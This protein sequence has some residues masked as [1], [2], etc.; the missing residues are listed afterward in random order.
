MLLQSLILDPDVKREQL[1][2]VAEKK[3]VKVE[4][5]EEFIWVG[6]T[7]PKA[8][9]YKSNNGLRGEQRAGGLCHQWYTS[10]NTNSSGHQPLSLL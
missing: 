3:V 2:L 10:H 4:R 1:R 5:K 6:S 7:E 9:L 8:N